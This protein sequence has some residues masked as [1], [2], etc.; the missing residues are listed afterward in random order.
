MGNTII[1]SE[2][3]NLGYAIN[4]NAK[5]T[6]LLVQDN[7]APLRTGLREYFAWAQG[8]RPHFLGNTSSTASTSTSSAMPAPTAC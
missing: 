6:G 7:T 3:R 4:A 1:N 8:T 5:P 2:F